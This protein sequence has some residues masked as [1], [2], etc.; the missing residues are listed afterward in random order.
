MSRKQ[1]DSLQ[2][3]EENVLVSS[4][5]LRNLEK[6]FEV[7]KVEYELIFKKNEDIR[8]YYKELKT[9]YDNYKKD[10]EKKINYLQQKHMVEFLRDFLC[11]L[12]SF[13][14]GLQTIED[15]NAGNYTSYKDGFL[16]TY[17]LMQDVLEKNNVIFIDPTGSLFDPI[18]HEAV[19][20]IPGPDNLVNKV[21][22]VV[23][24]GCVYLG[25]I[26]RNAKV[27][28]GSKS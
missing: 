2:I 6:K 26:I 13:D 27:V 12:D 19:A 1:Q 5:F 4:F 16:L 20:L 11:I 17:K 10:Q 23:Q 21:V 25:I 3:M 15:L 28:V 9:D 14:S 24:K 8:N 7:N 22:N 18:I